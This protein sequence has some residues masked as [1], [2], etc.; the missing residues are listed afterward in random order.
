MTDAR[1]ELLEVGRIHRAHGLRGEVQVSL[2]TDRVE[3]VQ[4]GAQ[5]QTAQGPLT[6]AASRPHQGRWLVRFEGYADR[7]SAETLQGRVLSAPP[8]DG[9]EGLWVHEAIGAEVVLVDGTTVGKVAAV[10]DNPAHDLIELDSGTLIPVVFLVDADSR[11]GRLVIDPPPG[12]L[13]LG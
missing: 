4:P 3:R 1:P 6:V 8:L 11:P 5:L 7:T 10:V 13:E 2:T 12:L 9:G